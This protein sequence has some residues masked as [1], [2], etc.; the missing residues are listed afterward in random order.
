MSSQDDS[1]VPDRRRFLRTTSRALLLVAGASWAPRLV[2]ASKS[3]GVP[4][5]RSAEKIRGFPF[6]TLDSFFT[7]TDRFFVRSHLEIPEIDLR[8]FRLE[9]G[10][11]VDRPFSLSFADLQRLPQVSRPVTFECSGNSVGGGMVS[12]AQWTGPLLGPMIA[13]AEPKPGAVELLMEGADAGLDEMV[14]VPVQYARS[15]PLEALK[16]IDGII[17][18]KMNGEVLKPEHGFPVRVILPGLYGLQNVKWLARLTVLAKPFR[19]FYQTQRYVGMRRTPAGI[20]VQEIE[21]QRIKS[22]IARIEAGPAAGRSSYRVTGA[23]WSGGDGVRKVEVSTDGG[24]VWSPAVLEPSRDPS[25]WVLWSFN[26]VG[27]TPGMHEVTARAT[28]GSGRSQPLVR[29]AGVLTGYVNNWCH[30]VTVTVPG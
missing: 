11:W 19:G 14:P 26:W 30:R 9:V 13:R 24:H 22:Q 16:R 15:V 12:T 23:A 27:A 10:G 8:R 2:A 5:G 21:K 25:A 17:A 20:Q 1:P 28:D 6:Q 7:P 3:L 18:L 29:D 4:L